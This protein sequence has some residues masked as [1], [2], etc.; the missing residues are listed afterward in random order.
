MLIDTLKDKDTM[1]RYSTAKGISR[2][3]CRLP[4]AFIDQVV[5]EILALFSSNISD[6][7]GKGEDLSNVSEFTWQGSCLA[8]AELARRG[9]LSGESLGTQL[10][11]VKKA[12]LFDVRRGAHSVGAGVRDAACYV[13]W[14]LARAHDSQS[15]KPYGVKVA[16][17]LVCVALFDRD[18]SIRRAAS[19]AFQECVGRLGV[20]PHGIDVIR[21]TDFYAVGVRRNAFLHCAPLVATHEVYLDAMLDHLIIISIVH[22]DLSMRELGGIVSCLHCGA[23]RQASCT[24]DCQPHHPHVHIARPI[25]PSWRASSAC[26]DRRCL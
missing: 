23:R 3:C 15:I 14:A 7:L 10:K 24:N 4:P 21:K 22:W 5:D 25:R 6:F 11:W 20:F 16:Q 17:T 2:L 1:V 18:I 13:L 19:A 26:R 8:L 12:L 9:L